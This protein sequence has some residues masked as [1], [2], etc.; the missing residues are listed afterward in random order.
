[1]NDNPFRNT[2][3]ITYD[4]AFPLDTAHGEAQ[5]QLWAEYITYTDAWQ[6]QILATLQNT[7]INRVAYRIITFAMSLEE[8]DKNTWHTHSF[9][10]RRQDFAAPTTIA[11][12]QTYDA[13]KDALNNWINAHDT[14]LWRKRLRN[15]DRHDRI[16]TNERLGNQY[17]ATAK[18]IAL[19][20]E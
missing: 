15:A 7:I 10:I 18:R 11:R 20:L 16:D 17:L 6:Y 1:M 3:A 12:T 8:R 9:T 13:L 19:E 4:N 2:P 5:V 14:P